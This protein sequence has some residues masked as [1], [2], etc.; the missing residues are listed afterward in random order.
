MCA[1]VDEERLL[2]ATTAKVIVAI[3]THVYEKCG[4]VRGRTRARV[5]VTWIEPNW[6]LLLRGCSFA[7][8]WKDGMERARTMIILAPSF[9]HAEQ[10]DVH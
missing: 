7:G 10:T 1:V 8:R 5:P 9:T 2:V 4:I 3:L 6:L